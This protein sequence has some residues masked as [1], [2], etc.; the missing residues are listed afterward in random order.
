MKF[1]KRFGQIAF[2][3]VMAA[4]IIGAGFGIIFGIAVFVTWAL[5]FTNSILGTI[6]AIFFGLIVSAFVIAGIETWMENHHGD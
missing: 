4:C 1:L 3:M 5:S 2:A 6:I